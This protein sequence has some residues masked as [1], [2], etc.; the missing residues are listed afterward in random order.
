M[1]VDPTG[2]DLK[3][4]LAEDP[5]G[6]VVMLNLLKLKPGGRS[7]YAEYA[8]R[9]RPFL[10]ELGAEIVYVGDCSTA[11]VAPDSHDWDTVL[12]VRYPSRTAFSRMVANPEYQ[13]ITGLRTAA[14]DNAVLQATTPWPSGDDGSGGPAG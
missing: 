6:P 7:S 9:I 5:G 11:L 4:Y 3:R 12:L 14:L 13:K 2:Q 10:E 8:E 1:P